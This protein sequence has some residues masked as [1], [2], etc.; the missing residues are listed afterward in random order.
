MASVYVRN[1]PTK[2]QASLRRMAGKKQ[3]VPA[4]KANLNQYAIDLFT[5]HTAKEIEQFENG[6][7]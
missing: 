4:K 6:K 7:A 2:V 3:K 5:K 1:L